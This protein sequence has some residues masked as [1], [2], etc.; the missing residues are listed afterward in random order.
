VTVNDMDLSY[1]I[2]DFFTVGRQCRPCF[3]Y[4]T[5]VFQEVHS[6]GPAPSP[7]LPVLSLHQVW[8]E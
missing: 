8:G 4:A 2:L 1:S 6:A 7:K 3:S 5:F